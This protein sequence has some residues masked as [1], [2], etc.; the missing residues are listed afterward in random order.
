MASASSE[1]GLRAMHRNP[2][3]SSCLSS[4]ATISSLVIASC[5]NRFSVVDAKRPTGFA[6]RPFA[7][8]LMS[9]VLYRIEA[10]LG[11][12]RRDTN[13]LLLIQNHRLNGESSVCSVG[14]NDPPPQNWCAKRW[15]R[16]AIVRSPWRESTAAAPSCWR[17]VW[18]SCGRAARADHSTAR[19]RQR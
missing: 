18:A 11:D 9:L 4:G 5:T 16:S 13:I 7:R 6:C 8:L 3:I 1:L 17:R 15:Q 2:A 19:R 14:Q 12:A 10:H